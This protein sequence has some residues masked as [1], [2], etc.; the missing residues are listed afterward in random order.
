MGNMYIDFRA[1]IAFDTA[2]V[3]TYPVNVENRVSS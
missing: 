3:N 1:L 2:I